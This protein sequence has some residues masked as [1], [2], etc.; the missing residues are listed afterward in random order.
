METVTTKVLPVKLTEQEVAEKAKQ[1]ALL[2]QQKKALEEKKK[3][4]ASL[5]KGQVEI[6]EEEM[7][8]LFH[9]VSK[10]EER[11]EVECNRMFDYDTGTASLYRSDTGE[12]LES[13]EMTAEERQGEL[14]LN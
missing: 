5:I 1:L 11:R 7:A 10:E 6:V 2:D 12:L 3:A 8:E 13:R 9:A 4:Q 14:D